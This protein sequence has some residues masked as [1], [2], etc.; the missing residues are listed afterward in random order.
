MDVGTLARTIQIIL[1]PVVMITACAIIL[2]GLWSHASAINDRLRA[3]NHERLEIWRGPWVDNYSAERLQE[4]DAQAPMLLRRHRRVRDAIVTIYAA[5]LVYITSMF[6]I[7]GAALL[8]L[9]SMGAVA[10]LLFLAGTLFLLAGV[11][12]AILEI[13][14]SQS[15]LEYEVNRVSSLKR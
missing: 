7:A 1:A 13:R 3:M 5:I 8:N 10:L 9:S 15:A 6:A 11:L 4:L 12:L 14:I 2:G